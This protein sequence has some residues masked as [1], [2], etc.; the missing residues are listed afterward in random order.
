MP[1]VGPVD[2][3]RY[4]NVDFSDRHLQDWIV[5]PACGSHNA[6]FVLWGEGVDMDL[7]CPECGHHHG[8]R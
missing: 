1:L 5:C 6:E 3:E 4:P 7:N 8:V 2:S